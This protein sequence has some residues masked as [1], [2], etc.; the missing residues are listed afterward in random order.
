MIFAVLTWHSHIEGG[1]DIVD[2]VVELLK[3]SRC[4][5]SAVGI[6]ASEVGLCEIGH[7]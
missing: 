7:T 1:A 2:P 5:G 4:H 3:S 6:F